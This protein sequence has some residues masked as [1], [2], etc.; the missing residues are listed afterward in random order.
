MD[1]KIIVGLGNPGE[2]YE[3]TFH[4]AGVLF[5]H[6]SLA[7]GEILKHGKGRAFTWN[8]TKAGVYVIPTTF[9]NNSGGA[10]KEAL[11]HFTL[12]PA[13][14][15][16]VHDDSDIPLGEFK[17]VYNR[18]SAGHHGVESVIDHLK[19]KEFWRLRIG[20]RDPL[21][22]EREDREK[23][24]AF[25]LQRLSHRESETLDQV[26]DAAGAAIEKLIEKDVP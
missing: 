17:L 13:D 14:L 9:M 20:I 21:A 12:T 5:V 4:N 24:G 11:R 8:A 7:S 23:A 1:F 15:L 2:E 22:Q 16:L 10:V 25:V 19:T 3:N 26:F 18:G 6:H